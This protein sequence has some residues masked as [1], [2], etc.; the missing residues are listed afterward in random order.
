M[1]TRC[2]PASYLQPVLL[3]LHRLA[4]G[5]EVVEQHRDADLVLEEDP[6][7]QN[8]PAAPDAASIV[9]E[10]LQLVVCACVRACARLCV[11]AC[12]RMRARVRARLVVAVLVRVRGA[13]CGVV[14][15]SSGRERGIGCGPINRACPRWIRRW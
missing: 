6:V 11:R 7:E 5:E 4:R 14:R 2:L 10:P 8:L 12:V 3:R 1:W 15:A 13:R 9:K